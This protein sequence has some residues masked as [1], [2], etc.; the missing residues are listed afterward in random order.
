MGLF[1]R[2]AV[3]VAVYRRATEPEPDRRRRSGPR[4][5]GTNPRGVQGKS[6]GGPG[7]VPTA[8]AE[9]QP[10]LLKINRRRRNGPHIRISAR[11][12]AGRY[13]G[14]FPAPHTG[15]GTL[16]IHP[17]VPSLWLCASPWH[18][19]GLDG[20]SCIRFRHLRSK[21]LVSSVLETSRNLVCPSSFA[22]S[23][24]RILA[25]KGNAVV[26]LFPKKPMSG[27]LSPMRISRVPGGL[28]ADSTVFIAAP[29]KSRSLFWKGPIRLSTEKTCNL[30]GVMIYWF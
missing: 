2:T 6:K 5:A 11:M 9:D 13:T 22:P 23:F 8:A 29:P 10:P 30:E 19:S 7:Q 24:D 28:P 18:P 25:R 14:F 4:G 1:Y 16:H 17:D 3:L 21:H 12:L 15:G 26:G 20:P 27:A